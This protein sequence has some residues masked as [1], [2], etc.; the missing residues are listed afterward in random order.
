MSYNEHKDIYFENEVF[1]IK[2]RRLVIKSNNTTITLSKNQN[3]FLGCLLR[4]TANKKDI[5]EAIWPGSDFNSKNNN[6]RQLLFQT[7]T[8]LRQ[9]GLDNSLLRVSRNNLCLNMNLLTPSVEDK[10]KILQIYK[11]SGLIFFLNSKE[12]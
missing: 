12:V 3:I 9:A 2:N 6:Y 1:S 5:I 8:L 11:D 7:R 10:K 4:G